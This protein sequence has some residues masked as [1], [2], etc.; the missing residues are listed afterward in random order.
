MTTPTNAA[1]FVAAGQALYGERWQ[2]PLAVALGW[3]IDERGQ[4]RTVQRIKAVADAGQEYRISPGVMADLAHRLQDRSEACAG[5]A[6]Q[7]RDEPTIR[8]HNCEKDA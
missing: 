1:L 4:N 2:Q 6:R 3:P 7:I 8:A 5:L